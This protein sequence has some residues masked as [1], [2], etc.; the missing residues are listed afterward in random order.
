M[1]KLTD[2]SRVTWC[3]TIPVRGSALVVDFE[4]GN[5]SFVSF[6]DHHEEVAEE[7]CAYPTRFRRRS[8]LC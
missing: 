8:F 1:L 4:F 3:I 2:A 6:L 5:M 7:R